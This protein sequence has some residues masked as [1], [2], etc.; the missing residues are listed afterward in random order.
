[1]LKVPVNIILQRF[2]K[3]RGQK[4][5]FGKIKRGT[6]FNWILYGFNSSVVTWTRMRDIKREAQK[7]T[8]ERQSLCYAP[9]TG[10]TAYPQHC[11]HVTQEIPKSMRILSSLHNITI[12]DTCILHITRKYIGP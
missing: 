4:K 8:T 2:R 9:Y 11:P 12:D 5:I 7:G 10:S 1:M 3:K 6:N